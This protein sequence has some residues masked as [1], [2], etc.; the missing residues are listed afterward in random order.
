VAAEYH[1]AGVT[2]FDLAARSAGF[3][4]AITRGVSN[5]PRPTAWPAPVTRAKATGPHSI[6]QALHEVG[7]QRIGHGTRLAEDPALLEEVPW[8]RK[9]P[10]EMCLTSN[11]HTH[12]VASVRNSLQAL[13]PAGRRRHA[14]HRWAVDGTASP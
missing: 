5:T 12:V 14:E 10:L 8:A 7:A 4:R 2:A 6:D 11:V 1:S 13:S 3:R 9:I